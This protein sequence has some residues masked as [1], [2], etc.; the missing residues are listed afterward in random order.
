MHIAECGFQA[1]HFGA[2]A[3]FLGELDTYVCI[4][5]CH[6]PHGLEPE[7]TK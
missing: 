3:G 5:W 7:E 2:C 6:K 4:C 1:G